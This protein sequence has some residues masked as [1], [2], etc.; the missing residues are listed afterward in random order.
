MTAFIAGATK[1]A[2]SPFKERSMLPACDVSSGAG[3]NPGEDGAARSDRT[4]FIVKTTTITAHNWRTV[5]PALPRD[6]RSDS[7]LDFLIV[8]MIH[9]DGSCLQSIGQVRRP[10]NSDVFRKVIAIRAIT[11]AVG[12]GQSSGQL[13]PAGAWCIQ[14]TRK[15]VLQSV[16]SVDSR[17]CGGRARD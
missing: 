7:P 2:R 12:T 6:L 16:P 10:K 5:R 8:A 17:N 11:E 15:R 3:M 4:T 1:V 14:A 9:P 13:Q